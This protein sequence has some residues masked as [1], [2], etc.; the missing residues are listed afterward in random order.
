MN[1]FSHLAEKSL[2][3]TALSR[4]EALGVLQSDD[5]HLRELLLAALSVREQFFGRRVKI[6]LL[7]NAR[8]GL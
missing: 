7:Q 6:S 1:T 4:D 2:T 8:S 5:E 3:G